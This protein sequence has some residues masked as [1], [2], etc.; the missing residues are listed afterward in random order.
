MSKREPS[1]MQQSRKRFL[2]RLIPWG[3]AM[4]REA[5]GLGIEVDRVR[6][7]EL[8]DLIHLYNQMLNE[9]K[10]VKV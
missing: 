5:E 1:R 9:R 6:L 7:E 8:P 4:L 3:V 2:R 10:E